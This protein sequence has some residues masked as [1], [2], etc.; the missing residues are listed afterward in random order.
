[1]LSQ[2]EARGRGLGKWAGA[3]QPD[4]P[5]LQQAAT[6]GIWN[7]PFIFESLTLFL[8]SLVEMLG[9]EFQSIKYPVNG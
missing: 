6:K 4:R 9:A 2:Q 3:M 5:P 1:M 7:H 8:N